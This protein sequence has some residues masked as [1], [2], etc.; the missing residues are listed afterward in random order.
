[1][2]NKNT[3]SNWIS[4]L[5]AEDEEYINSKCSKI[6]DALQKLAEHLVIVFIKQLVNMLPIILY[7]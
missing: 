3:W 7:G 1:M 6:N 4:A 5:S 2:L